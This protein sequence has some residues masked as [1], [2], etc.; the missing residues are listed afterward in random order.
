M[1]YFIHGTKTRHI[2]NIVMGVII[3]MYVFGF[4]IF[5]VI[6]MSAV[7][8]AMMAFL[9]RKTQAPVVMVWVLAYLSYNHLLSIL[10]RFGSMNMDISTYTMLLTCKL[11]ALAYCYQDGM[12]ESAKLNKDQRDRMVV[13][14]PTPLEF[15]S[16]VWYAQACALGVFFEFSD[17]KRFIER[18]HEYK[19]VPCPII[20]SLKW[21]AQGILCLVL[22]QIASPYFFVEMTFSAEYQKEYAEFSFVYRIFYYFLAMTFKRFFYYNPF[23]MTTGAIIAS[24]LGYNGEEKGDHQWDKIIG[25][26]AW[27]CETASSPIEMLRF[28]NH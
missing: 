2:F 6:V 23:S 20:P 16:Y 22:F 9:P 3:Q 14:F 10:Y 19:N 12:T 13:N 18:T 7:A 21:L 17:Y 26:Y 1:H 4:D 24:G 11:S 27:E 25:V 28:W 5:H 15:A 8:Y